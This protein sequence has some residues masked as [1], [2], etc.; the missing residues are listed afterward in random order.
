MPT[1][2]YQCNKCQK[3]FELFSYIKQYEE[4]P[5][6]IYCQSKKTKRLYINDVI[7]Q[8]TSIKK[9]DS[10]LKTLGDIALRNSERMSEDEKTSLKQKHNAYKE[11][12]ETKSLPKGMSR[13]KK[14]LKPKWKFHD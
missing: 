13:I 6:C 14:P 7:T 10:E 12:E 5:R 4:K 8:S 2:T 9:S 3:V 1:Y 11:V